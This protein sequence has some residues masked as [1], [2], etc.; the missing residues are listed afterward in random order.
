[1]SDFFYSF[2]NQRLVN[3]LTSR[4]LRL[5]QVA[6]IFSANFVQNYYL[7]FSYKYGIIDLSSER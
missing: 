2:T 4:I 5:V 7:T 6:Q 1:M 3:E